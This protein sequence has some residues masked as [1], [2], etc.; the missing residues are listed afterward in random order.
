MRF[1]TIWTLPAMSLGERCL[2][3]RDWLA[4]VIAHKLP[5][6]IRYWLVISEISYA[7]R[8]SKDI[9]ATTCS[10]ILNNLRH[11]KVVS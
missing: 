5:L 10:E 1:W 11:P 4:L 9:P 7:T 3:T 6:R 2:R 8:D